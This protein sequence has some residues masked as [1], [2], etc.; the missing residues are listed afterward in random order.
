MGHHKHMYYR[1]AFIL[2]N[3]NSKYEM[4]NLSISAWPEYL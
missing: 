1:K 2:L 3:E 4:F